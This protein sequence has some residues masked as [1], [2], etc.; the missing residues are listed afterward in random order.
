MKVYPSTMADAQSAKSASFGPKRTM[1]LGSLLLMKAQMKLNK[2]A[3]RV[4]IG[5]FAD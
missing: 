5:A 4:G 1:K 3:N 2:G